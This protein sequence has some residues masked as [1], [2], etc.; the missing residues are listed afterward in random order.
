MFK[1]QHGFRLVNYDGTRKQIEFGRGEKCLWATD[2]PFWKRPQD[3]TNKG[4][5]TRSME[6]KRCK[7]KKHGGQGQ[8]K[9]NTTIKRYFK[10]VGE[11]K[12]KND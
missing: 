3:S 5:K 7:D 11:N 12:N 1:I 4:V 2:E 10:Q 8:V 9:F 6:D